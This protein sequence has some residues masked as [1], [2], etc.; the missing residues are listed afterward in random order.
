[1]KDTHPEPHRIKWIFLEKYGAEKDYHLKTRISKDLI[2]P[3]NRKIKK[4]EDKNRLKQ[5]AGNKQEQ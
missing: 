1:Y 2:S 4:N 3:T 5:H